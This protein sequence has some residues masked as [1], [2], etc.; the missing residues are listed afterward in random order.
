M[1]VKIDNL[2]LW[3]GEFEQVSHSHMKIKTKLIK[4]CSKKPY[5]RID[6]QVMWEITFICLSNLLTLSNDHVEAFSLWV[7]KFG[8]VFK[9]PG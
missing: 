8:S 2:F 3:S 5:F 6:N 9:K 4:K 7:N 1:S